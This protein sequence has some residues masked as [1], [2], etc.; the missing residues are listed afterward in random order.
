ML[1]L[2]DQRYRTCLD[3]LGQG[4]VLQ[5]I[6]ATTVGALLQ[7]RAGLQVSLSASSSAK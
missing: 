3:C 2:D 6:G 7:G 1:R 5:A 4:K